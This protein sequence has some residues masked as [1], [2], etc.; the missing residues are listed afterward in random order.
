M[1]KADGAP[2]EGA[3]VRGFVANISPKGCFLRLARDVTGHVLMKD[4]ADDFVQNP[5]A[6]FPVGKLVHARVLYTSQVCSQ[7]FF[8]SFYLL[9]YLFD[10]VTSE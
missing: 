2:A 7:Y 4:L 5:I 10:G 1:V 3:V 8:L 9:I 6:T